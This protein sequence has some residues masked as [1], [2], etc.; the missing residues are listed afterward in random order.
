M[1][2]NSKK[3]A[4][5]FIALL[6]FSG[7][8]TP[9][10]IDQTQD[11]KPAQ[12]NQSTVTNPSNTV[13]ASDETFF[14]LFNK[15][16]D[17]S[18]PVT[19]D[20]VEYLELNGKKIFS[21]D[22]QIVKSGDKLTEGIRFKGAGEYSFNA[23]GNNKDILKVKLV[24]STDEVSIPLFKP[25]KEGFTIQ[26]VTQYAFRL[27]LETDSSG[28]VTGVKGVIDT[29]VDGVVSGEG[30]TAF[31]VNG[32]NLTYIN[33][34]GSAVTA[35]LSV[36]VA[37]SENLTV[38]PTTRNDIKAQEIREGAQKTSIDGYIGLWQSNIPGSGNITL[39]LRKTGSKRFTV[40]ASVAGKTYNSSGEFP[41]GTQAAEKLDVNLSIAGD[42]MSVEIKNPSTNSLEFKLISAGADT[43]KPLIGI[44]LIMS[45]VVNQ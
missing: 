36:V 8:A 9:A 40:S 22:I 6:I 14:T 28:N 39:N 30:S 23:T 24:G 33:S 27:V 43:L 26:A 29:L 4:S 7:C 20:Q 12:S 44:P 21:K 25:G 19:P 38:K 3:T 41:E 11:N 35:P 17:A 13:V 34:D 2:L 1:K 16:N 42:N 5:L 15:T 32:G 45:R 31:E 37:Q 10:N 18:N